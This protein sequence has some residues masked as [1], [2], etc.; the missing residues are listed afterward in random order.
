MKYRF[1][2]L[3]ALMV[4]LGDVTYCSYESV[5]VASGSTQVQGMYSTQQ[6]I[7]LRSG[8][9]RIQ[10][11]ISF[12]TIEQKALKIDGLKKAFVALMKNRTID[13]M[14]QF[15]HVYLTG[16]T[17]SCSQR[18]GSIARFSLDGSRIN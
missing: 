7:T 9:Y 17:I 15:T 1:Y 3:L 5:I 8:A 18:N 10:A 6:V 11:R 4:N 2:L 13:Q 14:N 12:F 16:N